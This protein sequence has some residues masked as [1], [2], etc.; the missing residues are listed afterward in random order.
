MVHSTFRNQTR[1]PT[2]AISFSNNNDRNVPRCTQHKRNE[3][4]HGGERILGTLFD[5]IMYADDT[6]IFSRKAQKVEM[7]LQRI[8]EEGENME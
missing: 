5:E 4:G 8:E 1:M 6:L 3:R 7:R 2:L